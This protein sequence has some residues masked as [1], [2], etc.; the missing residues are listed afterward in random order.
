MNQIN[1]IKFETTTDV[2]SIYYILQHSIGLTIVNHSLVIQ[3]EDT[4]T[5]LFT[6]NFQQNITFEINGKFS[7]TSYDK[8]ISIQL[9]FSNLI[10]TIWIDT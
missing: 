2:S 4:A 1:N 9:R 8:E 7:E 6:I 3:N 10:K 5:T